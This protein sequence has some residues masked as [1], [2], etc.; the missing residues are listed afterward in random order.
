MVMSP[1]TSMSPLAQ[2]PADRQTLSLEQWAQ[3]GLALLFRDGGLDR[4]E[5]TVLRGFFKE[6]AMRAQNG[7]IG[8][9]GTP[10][11]GPAAAPP[12]SPYEMNA[13]TEDMGTVQG[14]QPEEQGGY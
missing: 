5:M 9:G 2:A 3:Q 6:V 10:Q 7:G 1:E 11:A 8:A 13:N 14:A 4:N 12:Q